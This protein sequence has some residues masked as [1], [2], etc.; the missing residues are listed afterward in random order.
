MSSKR[1]ETIIAVRRGYHEHRSEICF[2][3]TYTGYFTETSDYT[4]KRRDTGKTRRQSPLSFRGNG[5]QA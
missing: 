5:G 1:I 2:M 4:Q 3:T